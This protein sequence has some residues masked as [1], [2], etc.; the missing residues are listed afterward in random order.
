MPEDC[1][2]AG[3]RFAARTCPTALSRQGFIDAFGP[4]YEHSPWIAEHVFDDGMKAGHD[5]VEG[6]HGA[7]VAVVAAADRAAKLALLR[8]H[9]DLA[10]K[11]AIAGDLTDASQS[12]QAGSGLSDCSPGEFRRFQ[13]LNARYKAKFG[14]PFILAVRG[15]QRAEILEAFENRVENSPEQEFE[16]ALDQVHRIAL[17]RLSEIA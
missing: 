3:R 5:T 11:L 6:L 14:F 16:A 4:V 2:D 9:P 8:A 15:R 1:A 13:E 7:M 17:L 12:E 10:G